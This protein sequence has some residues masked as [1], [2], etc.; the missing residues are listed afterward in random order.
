MEGLNHLSD[1]NLNR[2]KPDNLLHCFTT[3]ACGKYKTNEHMLSRKLEYIDPE[4]QKK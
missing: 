1:N 2:Y 3:S 4:F